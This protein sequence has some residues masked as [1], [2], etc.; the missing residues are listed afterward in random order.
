MKIINAELTVSHPHMHNVLMQQLVIAGVPGVLLYAAFLLY[1]LWHAAESFRRRGGKD[2]TV[3]MILAG[4]LISL[5]AYG[6]LEPLLSPR[7]PVVTI[8]F[9]LIAGY[10]TRCL[11]QE[12]EKTPIS[13]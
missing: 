8:L 5:M 10:F 4:L 13:V 9:L 6:M 7:T 2:G 11:P 12:Y 3:R 1:L